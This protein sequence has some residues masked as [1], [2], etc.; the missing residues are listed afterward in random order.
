MAA[1]GSYD[2][3][4][5]DLRAL[6]GK[7]KEGMVAAL[8]GEGGTAALMKKLK[9]CS[10]GLVGDE[11]DLKR[12]R[13]VF[14]QNWIP[15]SKSKSFLRLLWDAF[16]DPLLI[17]LAI[18]ALVGLG[19]SLYTKFSSEE[20][21]EESFEWI[22]PV[23]IVVAVVLV[24]VVTAVN[25][26]KKEKQFRGLQ[27]VIEDSKT[28]S[29]MRSGEVVE[30]GERSLV[31]GDVIIL[32]YGDKIPADGIL[33][34][35]SE[36]RVDESSM[37]G[38]NDLV[39]K[40]VE[41]DPLI[42]SSTKVMQ[43]SG[44]ALVTA[45]GENSQAG[46]IQMLLGEESQ[47]RSVLQAKLFTLT[48][49]I[50]A[51][52]VVI[53]LL[54]TIV[55]LTQYGIVTSEEGEK[56][57]AKDIIKRL[58]I[59]V[60]ILVVA[61]PEGLPLAVTI[62]LA[63][64][65]KKM[66]ADNNLVRHLNACETMGNA[67]IICTDKTGTLT[68]NQMTVVQ[69]FLLGETLGQGTPAQLPTSLPDPLARILGEAI[70]Y[71]SSYTSAVVEEGKTLKQ[72]GNKTECALLAFLTVSG[73]DYRKLRQEVP[74]DDLV[75]VWPFNSE[76]KRMSSC[77]LTPEGEFR[78]MTK[79]AAELMVERCSFIIGKDGARLPLDQAGRQGL[80]SKVVTPM[81]E[82]ALRTIAV[83]YKDFDSQAEV[84]K[85]E[86]EEE[87]SKQLT[88]LAIFGIEDPVREEV[89]MAIKQC[90]E[91]G[92]SVRMVT[93]DNLA[94][95]RAI[96]VKC[97]ILKPENSD[98][99]V[100]EG[101][102]FNRRVK[103]EE[104]KVNQEKLDEVWPQL[105]VLARSK[106]RDKF[107]LVQGIINSKMSA[108]REVVAVT[109]DGTNDAP[110]LKEA[111]VGFAMGIAGTEV[112]KEASDIILTDDNF[113]SIVKAVLWGRN[114]YDSICKFLQFQLTVNLVAVLIAFIGAAALKASPLRA[115]QM[116]WVNLIMDTLAALALA[117]ELPT[118]ELL[119]RAPYGRTAFLISPTMAR[120]I[121]SQ[122][123]FQLAVL[124]ALLFAGDKLPS[125]D[126]CL[127]WESSDNDERCTIENSGKVEADPK[128]TQLFTM[129]FNAFILMTL[130]NEVNCRRVHGERNV[131]KHLSSNL[132]FV[133]I[134]VTCFALQVLIVQTPELGPKVFKT[135][136]LSLFQWGVCILAG[137][138][139]LVCY[140]LVLFIPICAKEE[141][142][143]T[144]EKGQRNRGKQMERMGQP[145][146][147]LR[148]SG[149]KNPS[150]GRGSSVTV[151]HSYSVQE[152]RVSEIRRSGV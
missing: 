141:K 25:D 79:G 77:F 68:T 122:A 95:A 73:I 42:L 4:P 109:G 5:G 13:E 59:G 136:P 123:L 97:G 67:T 90:Q 21:E 34:R 135:A 54:T 117:T 112:A 71:N 64:S 145:L 70:A 86:D 63:Y 75:K 11:A 116:L 61:I 144:Q 52:G 55:L 19:M 152:D 88:L 134:W 107:T 85:D 60:T 48:I 18:F 101:E 132:L 23:A 139:S 93:G 2:L 91:A 3:S 8:E 100:L 22:E 39:K 126:F 62:S 50:G 10:K 143:A 146:L 12:R 115:L 72:M 151:A 7:R 87:L 129:V 106:P 6:M 56:V 58:M 14:G 98:F 15:A 149:R 125:K 89:P 45:V 30:V 80:I 57:T 36:L 69:A 103:D 124:L 26:W 119:K 81:T 44:K 53:A 51:A 40:S 105:G 113:N 66:M 82:A 111:D 9:T 127:T 148:S 78:L 32:K 49:W 121:F 24:M 46:D 65:V 130:F 128:P 114:V 96:A 74:E 20:D 92:I 138:G 1:T 43:G 108:S 133:G 37:T 102:E 47:G 147:K 31:V 29:V 94:T 35:S 33:L 27:E 28:Y 84:E 38:E 120:N 137:L 16:L 150:I 83:A 110:A 104:G 118:P 76:K 41:K 131:V 99:L 17:I 140:Q 142:T